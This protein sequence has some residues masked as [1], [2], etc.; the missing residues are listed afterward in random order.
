M[1]DRVA[2]LLCTYNGEKY[3]REQIES[4]INQTYTNFV[5]YIH[6]DG[7][8]D[9]TQEILREYEEKWTDK[10]KI[11]RY[12]NKEHGANYN[13]ASILK[14]AVNNVNERYYMLCDQDDIWL[15]RKVEETLKAIKAHEKDQ[16]KPVLVYCDQEIVDGDL[17]ILYHSNSELIRRTSKDVSLK[18]IIF[19]NIASGCCM[20]FNRNLLVEAYNKVDAEN[21]TMHDWWIMLVAKAIGIVDFIPQSLMLYRQYG[22]NTLGVDNNYYLQKAVK[23]IR[24]FRKSVNRRSEQVKRCIQQAFELKKILHEK[25]IEIDDINFLYETMKCKKL[26]RT[27]SLLRNGYIAGDNLFTLFFV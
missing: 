2:I 12:E 23:Y 1:D 8:Q 7:S 18:R 21:T 5:C 11:L 16:T 20:G 4:L 3:L 19:R 17:K 10:I 6:D 22:A 9:H 13:F 14:Y 25:N 24:S 27:I 15:P 26:K